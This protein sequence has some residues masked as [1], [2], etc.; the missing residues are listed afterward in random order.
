MRPAR[1]QVKRTPRV[2]RAQAALTALVALLG[3]S[4]LGASGGACSREKWPGPKPEATGA[5]PAAMPAPSLQNGETEG[6]VVLTPL[7]AGVHPRILLDRDRIG[8]LDVLSRTANASWKAVVQNCTE[9]GT[10]KIESGYEGEDWAN[11]ALDLALCGRILH[12][13]D[14]VQTAVRYLVALVDDHEAIGDGKGGIKSVERNDGYSIRNRGFLAAIAYDWLYDALSPAQRKHVADRFDAFCTWYTTDGYKH[15]DPIANHYMGYFGACA[16]G[17]VALD[18][19]DPRGAK[20]RKKARHM[21]QAEI[22]PAYRKVAGGDF[23]EGWQYA[24][25]P[26]AAMAL[27]A[28]AE[29]RATGKRIDAELPWLRESVT[30]QAHALHP[31]GLHT[32]DNADWSK[33]PAT[34][35]PQQLYAAAIALGDDAWGKQALFLARLARRPNDPNWNWLQAVADDPARRGDDPRK[36]ATS[37]LA[38]GTGTVFARTDWKPDAVWVAMN[39]SPAFGDHQHLDQGHFEIVRGGDR[40]IIDP[41]DYDSYSTQSHNSILVDDAKEN[42]RWPPNQG[43]WG[44]DVSITRFEEAGR[45][46]SA[47]ASFGAA[48]N[49]DSY[50]ED[51]PQRSVMRAERELVVSR[52]PLTGATGASARVVLYDRMTVHKPTY[53]V[54]WAAHAS[55]TPQL[56]AASGGTGGTGATARITLGKSSAVVT[57]LLPAGAMPVLRKE[58][59]LKSD[60][61]FTKNDPAEGIDST[62]IEMASPKGATERRFLHVIAVG[63]AGDRPPVATYIKGE[64][65]EGAALDGESYVFP[66]AGPQTLPAAFVYTAPTAASHHVVTGL[67]PGMRYAVTVAPQAGAGGMCRVSLLPGGK[68]AASLAGTLALDLPGCVAPR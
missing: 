6:D 29:T 65:A 64:G 45:S 4:L 34:P 39:S 57:T 17:G 25:I 48:Y 43:V 10:G 22:I 59:T 60:E 35:F 61:M 3:T 31:D 49:P 47:T 11:A 67:A 54:T 21:W 41:G 52:T 16:M 36:G 27:Y 20:M 53:G 19:D 13:P 18:G 26:G 8:V 9:A 7:R 12:K 37:Y 30:F 40:L 14:A 5:A 1:L 24:R 38:R 63:G 51:H 28:D 58:P 68:L 50:P 2:R 62:R 56:T 46:V 66:I 23:P 44:K 55:V 15:D 33:K 42:L 32:W